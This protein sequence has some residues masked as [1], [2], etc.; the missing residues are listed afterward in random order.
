MARLLWSE[1]GSVDTVDQCSLDQA[2]A[3]IVLYAEQPV[4]LKVSTFTSN[5]HKQYCRQK[6]RLGY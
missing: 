4:F 3:Q 5:F 2:L 1:V 6:F